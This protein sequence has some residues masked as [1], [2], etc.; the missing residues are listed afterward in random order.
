MK[1]SWVSWLRGRDRTQ[2][3]AS[4]KKRLSRRL[5]IGDIH[6][7]SRTFRALLEDE[8]DVSAADQLFLLGDLVSKGPDSIGVVRYVEELQTAGVSVTIVRG[9]HEEA[10]LRAQE[11]GKGKLKT[12]LEGTNNTALLGA[13]GK[14]LDPRWERLFSESV[15][16]ASLP[17]AL[18]VHGGVDLTAKAPFSDG[19]K[20][21]NA[22]ETIYDSEAAGGR[23]VIHGHTRTALSVI[24]ESLVNESPV[25]PLDNGA[26]G[27]SNRKPFKV[28]EYG[29]L[30]C[31]DLDAWSLHVQPNRD[32]VNDERGRAAFS[33][34]VHPSRKR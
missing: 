27:A 14:R 22:R 16:V 33:L 10:I 30:C 13:G 1:R 23:P 24:I 11:A 8:M 3:G 7:C 26:V 34:R 21:V 15:F 17:D 25:I 29:N 5:V 2:E 9:N 19:Y 31:L 12:I 6:G 4:S 20:I 18:L 32:V 28:S